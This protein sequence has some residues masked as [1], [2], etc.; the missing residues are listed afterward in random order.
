M[1]IGCSP[2][3]RIK[4]FASETNIDQSILFADPSL[5]LYNG[6]GLIKAKNMKEI[7]GKGEKSKETVSSFLKGMTWSIYKSLTHVKE[8]GDVY[9]VINLNNF[10][11][12]LISYFS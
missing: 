7:A 12:A 6:L 4:S 1:V 3:K 11:K 5:G 9:Q 10:L 2:A 8:S